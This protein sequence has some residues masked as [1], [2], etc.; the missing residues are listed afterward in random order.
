M[1]Y[2]TYLKNL[3]NNILVKLDRMNNGFEEEVTSLVLLQCLKREFFFTL[4]TEPTR[5]IAFDIYM[6][7]ALTNR[8]VIEIY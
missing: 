4:R 6:S 7:E 1:A 3:F 5:T 2:L 8:Y